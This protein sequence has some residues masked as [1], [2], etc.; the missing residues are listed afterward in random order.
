VDLLIEKPS[1]ALTERLAELETERNETEAALA[2][3]TAPPITLRPD[4]AATYREKARDLKAA[5]EAADEEKPRH[6]L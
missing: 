6:G 2:E 5:L 1:R 4:A 3:I